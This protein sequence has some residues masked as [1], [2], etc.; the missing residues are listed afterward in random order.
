MHE[1]AV[2]PLDGVET[3]V[4]VGRHR[5]QRVYR[6]SRATQCVERADK[7]GRGGI[8]AVGQID[9]GCHA[10]RVDTGIGASRAGPSDLA[11]QQPRQGPLDRSLHRHHPR[12]Y[13]P[14]VK[15]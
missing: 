1:I 10:A 11:A 3:G 14:A 6:D 13:L 2:H 5:A 12:L 7:L 15:G 4:R 8:E 9:M